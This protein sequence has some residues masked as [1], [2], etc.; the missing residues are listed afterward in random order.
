MTTIQDWENLFRHIVGE[1]GE[2]VFKLRLG[3]L[4]IGPLRGISESP[5][6]GNSFLKTQEEI[7]TSLVCFADWMEEAG[8]TKTAEKIRSYVSLPSANRPSFCLN[9][10]NEWTLATV[11][12][13]SGSYPFN[14]LLVKAANRSLIELFRNL[15]VC[16]GRESFH[17]RASS[18]EALL[19]P[20]GQIPCDIS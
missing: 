10:D 2:S 13:K 5:A 1:P 4:F 8:D 12:P 17:R 16:D 6:V 20:G 14:R 7:L 19:Q 15:E 3:V 11:D 18:A 9:K